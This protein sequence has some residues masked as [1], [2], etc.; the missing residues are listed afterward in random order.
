[1]RLLTTLTIAF[2]LASCCA[3]AQGAG[4]RVVSGSVVAA[5][6]TPLVGATVRA[7]VAGTDDVLVPTKYGAIAGEEGRFE[8]ALPVDSSYVLEATS[9]GHSA[10]RV[11]VGREDIAVTIELREDRLLTQQVQVRAA[12]R[13]RSVEDAC[14]RVESIREEVQQHAPFSPSAIDVLRRY[15]SCTSTRVACALDNSQSIRLRGL[16]PTY[17]NVLVDGVPVISGLGTIYGLGMIPAHALQTIS[18]AEGASSGRYGNG[19]VSGIVDLQTRPPTEFPELTVS[20]NLAD[21][22]IGLPG[23]RDFNVSYTGLAGDVGIAAFGSVNVHDRDLELPGDYQRVAALVKGNV[24]LDGAT[25]I[26]VSALAGREHRESWVRAPTE[27]HERVTTK[28]A[29]ISARAAHTFADEAELQAVTL[30]SVTGLDALM[31]GRLVD[32]TQTIGYAR[33]TYQRE[34]GDHLLTVGTELRI[35]RLG[36]ANGP[37]IAYSTDVAS[38]FVQDELI[39]SDMWTVMGSARVDHHGLAGTIFSPRGSLMFEPDPNLTMRLMA[40]TG[41]KG[42]ATFDEQPHRALHGQSRWSAND[43]FDFERSFTLNYDVSYSFV[44]GD[45]VGVDANFNTYYTTITGKAVAHPDSLAAGAIFMV[46]SDQPTRLAGLELQL[47]PTFGEHFSGSLALSLIDYRMRSSNGSFER[48]PL[49]P[50]FNLDAS[51][52]YRH[53]ELD[54]TSEIW[55]SHVGSQQLVSNILGIGESTP[56]TLVNAR[57]EK[58]FGPLAVYLGVNNILGHLQS[59]T[60]PLVYSGETGI[61]TDNVW[62]P[63]EGRE[64]FIG[65][66]LTIGGAGDVAE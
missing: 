66:R 22:A 55:A 65:F 51:L 4:T 21:H 48:I 42:Q 58:G 5:D 43:A 25:E 41:F 47:R 35:D 64:G 63:T 30:F 26:T 13:T 11:I 46:N 40:G 2:V 57:V 14:C 44:L 34:A 39:L 3:L 1:M 28:R 20:G 37:S 7:Y 10:A 49:A 9:L 27:L 59:T 36:V 33:A 52:M 18:I 32:A 6:G 16:E 62:G 60:M 61:V 23:E 8:L 31:L 24:L 53:A 50:S 54:L 38:A 19:A 12:R 56:Y 17:I 15:S 45:A 29:D